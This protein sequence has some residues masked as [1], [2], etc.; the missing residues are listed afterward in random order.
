MKLKIAVAVAV[1]VSVAL[2]FPVQA[3]E[4]WQLG[5]GRG[6]A[7]QHSIAGVAHRSVQFA[8]DV[9]AA[10]PATLESAYSRL[11]S[12]TTRAEE[13]VRGNEA[14]DWAQALARLPVGWFRALQRW[15]H[16]A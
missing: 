15:R 10:R 5:E 12:L 3:A 6:V 7:T 14:N 16:R 2:A 13:V 1:A 8:T 9:L 11:D 4:L